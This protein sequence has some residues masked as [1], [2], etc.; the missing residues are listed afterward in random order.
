MRPILHFLT[1]KTTNFISDP[2]QS[3]SRFRHSRIL[4]IRGALRLIAGA[5]R[6]VHSMQILGPISVHWLYAIALML[7]NWF[8]FRFSGFACVGVFPCAIEL[9][10][11]GKCQFKSTDWSTVENILIH[12]RYVM[13][14]PVINI[15]AHQACIGV[16]PCMFHS[17]QWVGIWGKMPVHDWCWKILIS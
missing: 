15:S 13:I 6:P 7:T 10:F 11:E 9:V 16:F 8:W 2:R 4:T 12:A 17:V 5:W 14:Q 3:S 1:L